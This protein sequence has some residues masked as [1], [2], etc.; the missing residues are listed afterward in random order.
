MNLFK[1]MFSNITPLKR[2]I[3]FGFA[4]SMIFIFSIYISYALK[5]GLRHGLSELPY[6]FILRAIPLFMI[7]KLFIYFRMHMY[8]FTWQYVGLNDLYNLLK[9]ST[10]SSGFVFV[11][12]LAAY[13]TV[14]PWLP[15]SVILMDY[16]ITFILAGSLRISKRIF[17]EIFQ[18]SRASHGK[19]TLIIGAGSVGEMILRDLR[20]SNYSE[21]NP[22]AFLD[23]DPKKWNMYI[24]SIPILG[25]LSNLEKTI[26]NLGITALIIADQNISLKI[27][28]ELYTTARRV[29]VKE[30][31]IVPKLYSLTNVEVT[32]KK[33]EDIHVEDLINRHEI[34]VETERISQFLQG[35]RIL[36]TGAAG[37]IG[38]EIVRQTLLFNPARLIIFEIDETEIFHLEKQLAA[39]F[40]ELASRIEYI[41]GDVRDKQKVRAVFERYRPEIIFSTAAYKHVPLMETNPDEAIK[42]NIFGSYN[43][44]EAADLHGVQKYI[45]ISTD[46]AVKPESVMGI[47]KRYGEYIASAFNDNSVTQYISVRFGNVLGSRGSV[48]PVFL[49]QIQK[50]GPVTVTHAEM[51]RYF[52]TIPEA[53]TLVLQAALLGQGGEVMV[54][55]MGEPI[56]I[57][58]LAEELIRLHGFEPEKDI[59]IA[60]TGIRPG[61]KLFE[62]ILTAEEGTTQTTHERIYS[63][64]LSRHFSMEQVKETLDSFRMALDD[65]L[66]A[67]DL[68]EMLLNVL[69]EVGVEE[70]AVSL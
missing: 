20:K 67:K 31:K 55:D 42:V 57:N 54:L 65:D 34:R 53:V 56:Y 32:V 24:H 63:A 61:E 60:Y 46:K 29:G 68:K 5:F 45:N 12:Y 58:K 52:M 3:F 15:K 23:S 40:P 47:T 66:P 39:S 64:I 59:E 6:N 43:L 50:G 36:V 28:K 21:Y 18:S 4:D 11:L 49:D 2:T 16:F 37:S 51:K 14:A 7:V 25:D 1:K 17:R 41:V 44:C 19:S 30:I 69:R 62:E 38:S 9:A 13:E 26:R 8:Q 48:V 10:I 35:K 33:L 22:V 27:T 70:K